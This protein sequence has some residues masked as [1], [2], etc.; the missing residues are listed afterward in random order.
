MPRLLSGRAQRLLSLAILAALLIPLLAGAPVSAQDGTGGPGVGE[1]FYDPPNCSPAGTNGLVVYQSLNSTRTTP[2]RALIVADES[3]ERERVVR[4]DGV[5]V[6]VFATPYP[7]HAIVITSDDEGNASVIEVIDAARGFRYPLDIPDG[8]LGSLIYPSPA[9]E[10]SAGSRFIVLSDAQ[11]Q[12]AYLVDLSEGA[13]TDLMAIAQER[14]DDEPVSLISATVSPDD[15][16]VL[17]V[18]TQSVLLI[19]TEN[20]QGDRLIGSADELANF[21]FL[22]TDGNPLIFTR[23]LPD[24]QTEVVLFN[25]ESVNGR[26]IALESDL[27]SAT[28]LPNG[29]AVILAT[30]DSLVLLELDY[31]AR[32]QVA[33]VDSEIGAVLMAPGGTRLTYEILSAEGSTWRYVNLRSGETTELPAITGLTPVANERSLRW[34]VFAPG[35]IVSESQ[36]GAVYYSLDLERGIT[37]P[38]LVSQD[39][40]SYLP[41]IVTP[42]E[43]R[44]ALVPSVAGGIQQYDLIDNRVGVTS[45]LLD[46]RSVSATLSPDGCWAAV[47][48]VV[49]DRADRNFQVYL[50]PLD[51]QEDVIAGETGI[52]PIWLTGA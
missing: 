2:N 6:R 46:G 36:G 7:N 11:Q 25:T 35:A 52:A 27:V 30:G 33:E 24:G 3:G 22:P 8:N 32:S 5:P 10:Q 19:P 4:L 39:G 47:A 21:H 20:P 15:L 13:V 45:S 41:P 43:G 44:Y 48:R 26:Q 14:A 49:G 51:D 9:T 50:V 37:L 34:I 42:G 31:L 17:L 12:V 1:S 23:A 40:V 29:E 16:R 28:P 38:T 18:T